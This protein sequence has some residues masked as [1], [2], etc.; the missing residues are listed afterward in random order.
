M[1]VAYNACFGGFGLSTEAL[2]KF[3]EKKGIT[4]TW[5]EQTG[6]AHNGDEGYKKVEGIPPEDKMFSLTPL[7]E[8]VGDKIEKIPGELFYYPDFYDETRSDPDLISVIEDLGEKANGMCADLQ[9]KN[10]PDGA[11]C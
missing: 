9:I 7:T 5:Y 11:R 1:K 3:A 8:D 6:Y 10:I 2:T 4:L